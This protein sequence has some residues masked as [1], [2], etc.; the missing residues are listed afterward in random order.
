MEKW[1]GVLGDICVIVF[2]LLLYTQMTALRKDTVRNRAILFTGCGVIVIFYMVAVY[3]LS[4]PPSICAFSCMTIPSLVL[5]GAFSKYRDARFF[6][7]FCFVDTVSL[8]V[9]YV[10]RY[11]GVLFGYAG[12]ILSMVLTLLCLVFLYRV[13]KPYFKQY[14]EILEHISTG[15]KRLTFSAALIYITMI[16]LA[17]YPRPLIERP[18][19]FIPYLVVCIMVLSFYV[20]MLNNILVTRKVYEQ[21]R[22]LQEQQKWF[23]MAYVD[24]L[25]Q[26]PNRMAY[27][28]KIHKLERVKD[29]APAVAVIVID[30]DKFKSINDTWGHSAGD[31]VLKDAAGRISAAFSDGDNQAYRIGGD[32]F[33][34]ITVGLGE[35]AI[36]DRLKSLEK[37]QCDSAACSISYGISYG[38]AF[39]NNQE[40]NAVEQAFS[41]ADAM[42]YA[43]K[44]QK[45]G[46][47]PAPL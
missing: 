45:T 41:R 11:I 44:S 46:A 18:E 38:C 36:L 32:E 7:T 33:A 3:V 5:F 17:I 20:V 10:I 2:D 31:E 34:V 15:W 37:Q 14:R 47:D 30:L 29:G 25:T 19:Y 28:E 21:S 4:W 24:A 9:G 39:V 42:M 16:V 8:I 12:S 43:N 1:I 23:Q 27:L 40:K 35:A 26:I 6:L 13:A 22:Q